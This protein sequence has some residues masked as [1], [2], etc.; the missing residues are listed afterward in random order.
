VKIILESFFLYR[1]NAVLV[2]LSNPSVVLCLLL[3][4]VIT[5]RRRIG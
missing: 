3:D 2:V 4:G 5:L 1:N